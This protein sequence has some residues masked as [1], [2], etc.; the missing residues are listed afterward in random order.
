[1]VLA[2]HFEGN[3]AKKCTEKWIKSN[4]K[5]LSRVISTK[6]LGT[7]MPGSACLKYLTV[8][9]SEDSVSEQLRA[10]FPKF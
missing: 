1:M 8:W 2:G 10:R 9:V 5:G 4:Q 6:E 7:A 3:I